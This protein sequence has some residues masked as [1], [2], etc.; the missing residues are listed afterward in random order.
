MK[1]GTEGT[2]KHSLSVIK[3]CIQIYTNTFHI[4]CLI[5]MKFG[6]RYIYI[7]GQNAVHI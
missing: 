3:G 6:L 5:W 7:Y 4:Y 1:F 2:H